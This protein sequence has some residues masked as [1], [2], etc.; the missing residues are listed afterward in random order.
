M[1]EQYDVVVIGSGVGGLAAARALAQFGGHRVLILE[2]HY[3]PGGMTHEFTRDDRFVFGTGLHYM[4]ADAGPFL[5]FLTDGRVQLTPLPDDYDVLH[6]PDFDFTV[7]GSGERFRERLKTGFPDEAVAI[8]RFFRTTRR[9]LTGLVARN[10]LASFPA[11]VRSAGFGLVRRMFPSAYRSVTDQ[12]ARSFTD[13]RLRAIIAA[14]WGLYGQP[15]PS[16]AFGYHASVP[17]T[18]FLEGTS[19]PVGGPREIA[20]IASETLSPYG[21][22][23]RL[24]QEVRRIVVDRGRVTAV[25]VVER[26]TGRRYRVRAGIVVS[27]GGVRNTYALL[28]DQARPEWNRELD[29]LTGEPSALM[30]F[31]G[32]DRS[33][34]EFG[35]SGANHWFM[36]GLDDY[37]GTLYVSFA[38]L[39]NPA[40]RFHTIEMLE[41]VDPAVVE[42]WRGTTEGDRPE[43]YHAFKAAATRRLI[44]RLDAQWPGIRESIVYAELATPLTYENYQHSVRGSFYGLPATPARL[45]SGRAGSRTPVKGLIVAGQDAWGPGVNAALAGG[46]MAANSVLRPAQMSKMWRTIRGPRPK[47]TG[48]WRGFLRVGGIEELTPAVRRIRLEPLD[49]GALPF[50]FRAGQYLKADLPIGAEPI[51]RSYSICS[52]PGADGYVEIAV[53]R[54]PL[55]LGSTFL[56]DDLREGLAL[57][58]SGPYGEFTWDGQP[59]PMLLIAGGIGVTPLMSVLAAAADRVPITLLLGCRSAAEVPFDRELKAV[60]GLTTELYLTEPG[61]RGRIGLEALRPH[62]AGV[63]R[64]HLC[65]PAAM[66]RD[67][68]GAL[69]E[70]GVP[71]DIVHTEAFVSARSRETRR[72][73]AHAVA[74]A[75]AEAGVSGYTIRTAAASFP[76]RPGQTLLDAAVD[77]GVPIPHDCSEGVC[78]TCRVRILAGAYRT[79]D[80]GMFAPAELDQ[81]WRL[82]C[83]TLPT[84]DLTLS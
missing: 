51:E 31:L 39:N 9:A 14:R 42:Q 80:R 69:A 15:P 27:A 49:G 52:G 46:I 68:L 47:R 60:P 44:D 34:D 11:P 25:D 5:D 55:G 30:L 70:L 62:V 20:A 16:S 17:L 54:E 13:P 1:E 12:L 78:G 37:D 66:M 65:G 33:P 64:V 2:Q 76:C 82:A 61:G 35:P 10:I 43:S 77:A 57:R 3:L 18:F 19:H 79:D 48:P 81:G 26:A 45:R 63:A 50:A 29:D 32:L 22:E 40:A 41:L 84:E 8:D 58:V 53:K 36:P 28:G 23:L 75:A 83:Q 6:F 74:L 73:R 24:N 56:H 72:E 67:V 71:R 59:G 21:V 4:S 38:S 7:P